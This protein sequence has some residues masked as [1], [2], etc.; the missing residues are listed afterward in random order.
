MINYAR[1]GRALAYFEAVGF[2]R[3]EAP[4]LLSEQA[5]QMC[6]PEG[7]QQFMTPFGCLPASGEQSFYEML[8]T[9]TL[10]KGLYCCCTPCFRDET[11]LDH[12][13][14]RYFMKVELID[15]RENPEP[16]YLGRIAQEFTLFEGVMADG[17]ETG[18]GYD[19]QAD[20]VEIGSYG[21]RTSPDGYVW[22]YGTGLAE[23]RF[24]RVLKGAYK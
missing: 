18:S 1:I 2:V 4:W 5:V 20:G 21:I 16:L 15:T 24:T 12:L 13:H 3:I 9:G 8:R 11:V 17:I 14:Q 22:A 7:K 19:L 6:C 10:G 23:P